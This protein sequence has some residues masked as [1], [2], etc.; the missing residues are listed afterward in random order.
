LGLLYQF[1]KLQSASLTHLNGWN[2]VLI[3]VLTGL[4][5]NNISDTSMMA[6]LVG[7][8]HNGTVV[9]DRDN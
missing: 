2:E 5:L 7:L 4:R 9:S 3:T 1:V 6:N 8:E